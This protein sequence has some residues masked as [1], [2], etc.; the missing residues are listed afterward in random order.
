MGKILGFVFSNDNGNLSDIIIFDTEH[1]KI[2][3]LVVFLSENDSHKLS[4]TS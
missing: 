2:Y 3:V 1:T 4:K